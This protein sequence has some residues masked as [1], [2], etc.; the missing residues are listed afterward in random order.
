MTQQFHPTEIR[1]YVPQRHTGNVPISFILS[2]ELEIA[3]MSIN[4]RMGILWYIYS[5]EYDTNEKGGTTLTLSNVDESHN[6]TL[7]KSYS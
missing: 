6:T 3:Q 7:N 5:V 4:S 2:Q 1:A